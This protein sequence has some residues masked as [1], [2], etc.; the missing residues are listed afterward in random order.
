MTSPQAEAALLNISMQPASRL[1]RIQSSMATSV[2]AERLLEMG[3]T[4][5]PTH[6]HLQARSL[7]SQSL[8]DMRILHGYRW[9]SALSVA[10][11]EVATSSLQATQM[12]FPRV[13]SRQR[14]HCHRHHRRP[15]RHPHH[16]CSRG[17]V[18]TARKAIQSSRLKVPIWCA[19]TWMVMILELLQTCA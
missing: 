12:S 16:L 3:L 13:R 11:M 14:H 8:R 2:L 19:Q 5:Q 15:H 10:I 9:H 4:T 6:T 1:G 17:S 18:L 7:L